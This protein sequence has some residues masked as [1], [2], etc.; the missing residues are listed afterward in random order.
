M[1]RCLRLNEILEIIFRFVL[2]NQ[3]E[4]PWGFNRHLSYGRS[5]T[6]AF[7]PY[8]RGQRSVLHLALTCRAFR[9]PALNVLWSYLKG[10]GPLIKSELVLSC[11]ASPVR[12]HAGFHQLVLRAARV[13]M[14]YINDSLNNDAAYA[15]FLANA[16][17]D[18]FLFPKLDSLAWYDRNLTSIPAL[19]LLLPT[20]N[21]L[22]LDIS[23]A[24]FRKAVFPGLCTAIPSL[25]A[26]DFVSLK[27]LDFVSFPV[28]ADNSS[29]IK[30]EIESL[31]FNYPEGL[32][33]LSLRCCDISNGLLDVIAPWPHL[34]W[35]A[36]RMGSKGIPSA[37]R[38]PQ[39]FQALNTLLISCEHLSLFGSFLRSV[40]RTDSNPCCFGFP[41]LKKIT[42]DAHHCSPA[43]IW[44]DIFNFLIYTK[45]EHMSLIESCHDDHYHI[46]SSLALHPLLARPA[47]L[48]DLE[49]LVIHTTITIQ[50]TDIATLARAC[51]RLQFIDLAMCNPP[52]SLYALAYLVGR[53]HELYNVALCL[54]VRLD[55]LCAAPLEDDDQVVL[56]PNMCL[57]SLHVG[58]SPI[59]A[60][61][62]LDSPT[63]PDLMRSIPRFLHM[64]APKLVKVMVLIVWPDFGR[65][66]DRFSNWERWDKVSRVLSEMVQMDSDR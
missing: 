14:L 26:L 3:F 8:S 32:T 41:S 49:T 21:S 56:R 15:L 7:L 29:E 9:E 64:I 31:L 54:D 36:F 47:A 42:T 62:P 55:A 18:G 60:A 27:A 24:S 63:A 2:N 19:N 43:S 53:C 65:N 66:R 39:P 11:E 59:A 48:A 58:A 13:Q 40:L 33:K 35:L 1:H 45:L 61:G 28:T 17:Q 52:I 51:P 6:P 20:L 37:L 12:A 44:S 46:L 22:S 34:T 38:V 5:I 30:F 4:D 10:T 57:T 16:P 50:D 23:D 25:K